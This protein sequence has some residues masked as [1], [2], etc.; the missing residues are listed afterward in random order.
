MSPNKPLSLSYTLY[1]LTVMRRVTSL[2]AEV[3]FKACTFK[4]CTHLAVIDL[5]LGQWW[6]PFLLLLLFTAGSRAMVIPPSTPPNH[7]IIFVATS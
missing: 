7:K 4:A 1:L 6:S 5:P 2:V 3:G